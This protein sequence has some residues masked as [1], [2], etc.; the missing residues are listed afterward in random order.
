MPNF[1]IV[2]FLVFIA[3][4]GFAQEDNDGGGKV[5]IRETPASEVIEPP[6]EEIPVVDE[7]QAFI[8]AAEAD[9][10]E[11]LKKMKA[12][13]AATA[14][15]AEAKNPIQQIH[16]LGYEQIDAAALMDDKVIAILQQTLREGAMGKTSDEDFKK[17]L[18]DKAKGTMMENVFRRFPKLLSIVSDILR[19]KDSLPGLL[20]IMGRKEDLKTYGYVWVVIFIFGIWIKG[21]LVNPKWDFG[22]RFKWKFCISLILGSISFGI[23]Y[24]LFGNE[25]DPTLAIIG[26][27]LF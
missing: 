6:P 18:R 26:K 19:D 8:D 3:L 5:I 16:D 1:R 11:Q 22:R 9:R 21:K 25:I 23:F 27:H 2:L 13:E 7:D 20:G 12:V 10:L 17:M 14:P 15:I 24:A 4:P